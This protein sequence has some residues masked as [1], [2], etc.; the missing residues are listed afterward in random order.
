[1]IMGDIH[2]PMNSKNCKSS[3]T[4][5]EIS[6]RLNPVLLRAEIVEPS[7]TSRS[8]R[9]QK[10]ALDHLRIGAAFVKLVNNE[11]ME[12]CCSKLSKGGMVF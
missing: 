1:M 10:I 12:S 5:P 2:F 4:A 3:G 11:S 6:R 9:C 8:E 7:K